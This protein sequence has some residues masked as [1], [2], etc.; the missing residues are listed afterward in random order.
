MTSASIC[1]RA[2]SIEPTLR[3]S[4]VL[5]AKKVP[6]LPPSLGLWAKYACR[7]AVYPFHSK[8]PSAL[9]ASPFPIQQRGRRDHI[10]GL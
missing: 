8:S 2:T 3:P 4:T 5:D 9:P 6:C 7:E 10:E 1:E